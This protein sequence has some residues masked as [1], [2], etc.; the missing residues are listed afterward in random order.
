MWGDDDLLDDGRDEVTV[1]D[2]H[3]PVREFI[4]FSMAEEQGCGG[5]SRLFAQGTAVEIEPI[6]DASCWPYSWGVV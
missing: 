2:V 6:V 5:P 1:V 4:G 3:T